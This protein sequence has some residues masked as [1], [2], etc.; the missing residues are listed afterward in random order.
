[1]LDVHYGKIEISFV[2]YWSTEIGAASRIEQAKQI[3]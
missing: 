1:M 2:L 3:K